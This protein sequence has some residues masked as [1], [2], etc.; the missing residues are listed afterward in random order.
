MRKGNTTEVTYET[1]DVLLR[2]L[3][4]GLV[5][6]A[7]RPS[8]AKSVLC[9]YLLVLRQLFS[10]LWQRGSQVLLSRLLCRLPEKGDAV[11]KQEYLKRVAAYRLAMS[12]AMS[13]LRKGII[14]AADYRKIDE[15]LAQK[16]G[17]PCRSIFR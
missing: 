8:E 6:R 3:P 15:L 1:K 9:D 5:E 2:L 14:S 17:L 10:K 16:Y 4:Y 13:M 11:M 12:L 7:L